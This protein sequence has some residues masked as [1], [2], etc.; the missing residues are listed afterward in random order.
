MLALGADGRFIGAL[1]ASEGAHPIP[2]HEGLTLDLDALWT[3]LDRWP[4]E[5]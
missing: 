2:G 1:S 4:D 3:E 5:E